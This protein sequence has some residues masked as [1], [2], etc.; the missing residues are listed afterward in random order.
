ME[1]V[2]E[3]NSCVPYCG[4]VPGAVMEE[5]V[6]AA[7][8]ALLPQ[9]LQPGLDCSHLSED[10]V[11]QVCVCVYVCV[12]MHACVYLFLGMCLW[13]GRM[14][15]CACVGGGR[16]GIREDVETLPSYCT[17]RWPPPLS[18]S[19]LPAGCS[20]AASPARLAGSQQAV[21]VLQTLA[22]PCPPCRP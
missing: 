13:G 21:A 6:L 9:E 7:L 5:A 22:C 4:L 17:V 1:A 2:Y 14:C 8:L 20:S 16:V 19:A 18:A 12:C 11:K 3:F 10:D 15:C